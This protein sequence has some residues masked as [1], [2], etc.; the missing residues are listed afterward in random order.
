[1][2]LNQFDSLKSDASPRSLWRFLIYPKKQLKYA[3][4]HFLTV[5]ISV[6]IVNVVSYSKYTELV[7]N[8]TDLRANQFLLEYVESLSW[9]TLGTLSFMGLFSFL[10][11]I[12]LLHRFVGPVIPLLRHLDAILAGNF[13]HKTKLRESDELLEIAEKLNQVSDVLAKKKAG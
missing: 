6:L 3:Y 12:V 10:F 11:V 4:F 7:K 9:V 13:Q 2:S 1:M 5:C 8:Q